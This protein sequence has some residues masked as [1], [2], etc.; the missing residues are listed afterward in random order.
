MPDDD[1]WQCG[2]EDARKRQMTVGFD[3]TPA[4]RLAWLEG[5]LLFAYRAGALPR[6]E[7][8]SI[9]RDGPDAKEGNS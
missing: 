2:W 6:P 5:M 8:P 1:D 7:G 9:L 4:E 3:V